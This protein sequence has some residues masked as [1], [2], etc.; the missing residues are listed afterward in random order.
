MSKAP[1]PI[2][3]PVS[4]SQNTALRRSFV[5]L[6]LCCLFI[7]L[8][9][10]WVRISGSGDGCGAHWPF[11]HGEIIPEYRGIAMFIEN[12]HR[13]T[14]KAF[15]LFVIVLAFIIFR[16]FPKFHPL[17]KAVLITL[18]LTIIEGLLGAVLV[19]KGL[20]GQEE[21]PLR[22]FVMALHLINTFLL[23]GSIVLCWVEL[24]YPEFLRKRIMLPRVLSLTT[25]A[26]LL[27]W[28]LINSTGALAALASTLFPSTSLLEGFEKDF[29]E[30]SHF[31]LRLR[32]LHPL[33]AVSFI[34]FAFYFLQRL[35][36]FTENLSQ[37]KW[38]LTSQIFLGLNL[39]AGLLTLGLLSPTYMKLVHLTLTHLIWISL[40]VG[41][42]PFFIQRK[43]R[44][45]AT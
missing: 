12:F 44:Q 37:R 6:L 32:I 4:A 3:E 15:G 8:W 39:C 21:S 41:V 33:F 5:V 1:N 7:I 17:R 19:L 36:A 18:V 28:I 13:L 40:C 29:S 31:S 16:K 35:K 11:C 27:L 22:A 10:A 38:M 14:S 9:G 30:T 34:A 43:V 24:R 45:S 26:L 2:P 23:T 42:L 20:V 25:L